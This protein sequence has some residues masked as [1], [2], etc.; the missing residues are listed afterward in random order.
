MRIDQAGEPGWPETGQKTSCIMALERHG[1]AEAIMRVVATCC[2]V[3]ALVATSALTCRAEDGA[4]LRYYLH[5][6]GQDTNPWTRVHDHWGLSLGANLGRF[7]GLELSADTFERE[8]QKGGHTL[9]EYGV[10]ALVPQLRLR[11]PF[12]GDRL[13]PYVVGGAGVAFTEFND[14]KPRKPP[15]ARVAIEGADTSLMVGTLGAG[16]E[17]YFADNLAVGAEIKYLFAGDPTFRIDGARH[18]QQVGSLF[19][20]LG[21]RLLVPERRPPPPL[22]E[23][24]AA[25]VRLYFGIRAGGAIA[26]GTHAFS[27]VEIRPE[28]PAYFS[29]ANQ[30]FGVA[31][32]LDLGRHLGVELAADGYEIV[33]ATRERG[34]L[35]E[36][37]LVH[38]IPQLRVR[39]P[40]L[41]GSLVPY[42]IGGIGMG[43]V[44]LNDRKPAGTGVDIESSTFGIAAAVGAGVEYFVAS[45]IAVGLETRYLTSRGHTLRIADGREASGHY[46]AVT[47]ALTLR[48]FVAR[49]GR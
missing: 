9:G 8:V 46:D 13:V 47:V 2:A 49:F 11:Y 34:S 10:V 4:D 41:D 19:T 15:S 27:D 38:V 39:Y 14:R 31:L 24:A 43:N 32:G 40:L 23:G 37:A 29:T 36:V 16:I 28:P 25:P 7:W 44:E 21:L 48:V 35:T 12:F 5:L 20:T 26:T 3:L 18:S 45:N 6:R 30:F 33:L 1:A 17:Y 42:A 22:A